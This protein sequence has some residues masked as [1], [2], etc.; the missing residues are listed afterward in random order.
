MVSVK[1]A[2]A[3]LLGAVAT[4]ALKATFGLVSTPHGCVLFQTSLVFLA[5]ALLLPVHYFAAWALHW[6][7]AKRVNRAE[8]LR[9]WRP[10][11]VDVLATALAMGGLVHLSPSTHKLLQYSVMPIVA[12]IRWALTKNS[13][14]TRGLVLYLVAIVVVVVSAL[15]RDPA[16]AD[17]AP[18]GLLLLGASCVVQ[19]VLFLVDADTTG[20]LPPLVGIGIQGLWGCFFLTA[21]VFPAAYIIPTGSGPLENV[22][23][24]AQ[25]VAGD[26]QLLASVLTTVVATTGFHVCAVQVLR[27]ESTDYDYGYVLA[28]GLAPVVWAVGII[29]D[30]VTAVPLDEEWVSWSSGLQLLGMALLVYATTVVHADAP[31]LPVG[32]GHRVF[33]FSAPDATEPALVQRLVAYGSFKASDHKT[34]GAFVI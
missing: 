1:T 30:Y 11:A 16:T 21:I 17:E 25:V 29:I 31:E 26:P 12:V 28:I 20:R 34:R 7:P 3:L 23:G 15:Y 24:V 14:A 32:V 10:A 4:L 2:A 27:D 9:L 6:K 5:M 8:L 22:V 19:S 18:L 13:A 33:T